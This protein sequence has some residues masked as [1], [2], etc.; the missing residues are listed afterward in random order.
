MSRWSSINATTSM[1]VWTLLIIASLVYNLK[2]DEADTLATA[3][4]AARANINKD[5][6][7]RKWATSHGGVYVPPTARTPPNPYM[8][9]PDQNVT[10]TNNKALTLM[11]PAYMLRQMQNEFSKEYGIRSRITSLKPLNPANAPDAWEKQALESFEHGNKEVMTIQP[12]DGEPFLRLMLPFPV[13]Q[14][15]LKCH[16][17]QGYKIGDIRGGIGT[18]I[19]MLPHYARQQES[20]NDLKLP[21]GAIWLIGLF[22]LFMFFRRTGKAERKLREYATV[23]ENA[24]WGMVIAEA[25]TNR[26]THVNAAYA[27]MH[28]QTIDEL[29]GCNLIES[30]APEVRASVPEH[31][32]Q[33]HEKG[34]HIFE[35][36]HVRKDGSTFPCQI[37]VTAY[38]DAKGTV[39]FRAATV[40]DITER[41]ALENRL[42]LWATTFDNAEFGL[43]IGDPK[44]N[45]II[46]VN[47]AFAR[48]RGF[49]P[50]ELAGA[51]VA[52][53][54]PGERVADAM[55]HV[56]DIDANGHGVFE[57]EHVCKDG[58]HFPVLI[59]L[60]VIR[61]QD[62]TT[63]VRM[64]YVL[65]IS[66]RRAAEMELAR[67]R[68]HLEELVD[69]RTSELVDAK[70]AAEAANIAK[71][72][73][74]ANMSHEIRTPLNAI[75]GMAHLLRRSGLNTQ[76]TDKLDKIETAGNHLL[77]I[78]NAI[79]DLS[80]IEAGKFQLEESP[81]FL[82][83]IVENVVSMTG[84]NVRAKGLQI[85]TSV[86]DMPDGL[87]GDRTRLQQALLN[88]VSN[89]V[90]FTEAGS[91][92][93]RVQL[94]EDQ[95][96][97]ALIRFEVI[98]TGIGIAPE[99][100]QRLFSAFEQA[101]NSMTRKYGGTGLGLAITR[102][103]AE[104]MGGSAG[105]SSE[106]NKGSTFWFTVRL[107]KNPELCGAPS[108]RAIITEAE[109][110][111]KQDYPGMRILLAED[112]PVNREVSLSLLED[113][114]M[115][116]DVAEDGQEA[117]NLATQND[118]ALILMDMQMPNMDGL[119][120]TRRIRRIAGRQRTPI[121]AMTA[122]AFADDK[123]KCF[124]VGM[125]DFI[126]KPVTPGL[127]YQTLL[128]WLTTER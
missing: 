70:Q 121:L 69:Q 50:E 97:N 48:R 115:M 35:S 49:T 32:R 41:K 109:N 107:R 79:L 27:H 111:L 33:T 17:H 45:K 37:D 47:P 71:S 42:H 117:L 92:T 105:C 28:G 101:D 123:T 38:K 40:E 124:D 56:R 55:D 85:L 78:I 91:I 96:E 116:V 60:T 63:Q 64:A 112:E 21:H 72:S 126:P 76:Q 6:A 94:A 58:S 89:A 87:L 68:N 122:N 15:C 5:I 82:G 95:P 66:D 26:I 39:L 3:Q 34:H 29:L 9:V 74:L 13:E 81:I 36:V 10:T 23:F 24:G 104:I 31:A 22:S 83:E 4:V 119:E 102:K 120:A 57:S 30:Y 86:S 125:D 18:A 44:N 98:D 113:V 51:P 67:Y 127:L 88:F 16:G 52:S 14:G 114:G 73:F 100:L 8:S 1:V 20:A 7:F 90:K 110:T 59:D 11:N 19:S 65:D 99:A 61:G 128:K 84:N 12:M 106:P 43:A 118:Y 77:E 53:L 25:Q 75:T 80:K 62:G 46:A 108:G 2:R 103:I 54:F 93:I